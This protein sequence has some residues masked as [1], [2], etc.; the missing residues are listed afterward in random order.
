MPF[1]KAADDLQQEPTGSLLVEVQP[2]VVIT[3][4]DI[5]LIDAGLG[6]EKNGRLQLHSNLMAE[7]INPAEVT[8]VL[9]SH[10]HK[11]HAGGVSQV[12]PVTR[13]YELIFPGKVLCTAQG[14]GFRF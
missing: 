14:D 13:Q 7:G 1:D 5:I 9:M 8:K 6:F 10:L 3:T 2:F 4:D 11:D 12:N